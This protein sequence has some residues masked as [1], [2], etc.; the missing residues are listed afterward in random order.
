VGL[1][2]QPKRE[3]VTVTAGCVTCEDLLYIETEN[4]LSCLAVDTLIIAKT[5]F[6]TLKKWTEEM[7]DING[8]VDVADFTIDICKENQRAI[9]RTVKPKTGQGDKSTTK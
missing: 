5:C 6:K 4:L 7:F 1:D 8:F 9:A 2:T 3:C